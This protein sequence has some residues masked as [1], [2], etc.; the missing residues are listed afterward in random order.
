MKY[1]FVVLGCLVGT[2]VN[3]QFND[4]TN[5]FIKHSS[6]G[7]INK[8]NDQNSYVLNNTLRLNFYRKN[9]SV[10]TTNS[11]IYG[12]QQHQLANND[13]TATVDFDL[14]K[15]DRH[16][17]YWGLLNYEKS[18]SLKI[19]NRFQGGLGLGYYLIDRKAIV[20]QVSNGILYERSDLSSTE[21]ID[22]RDYETYRNSLRFKLRHVFRDVITFEN[23]DLIQHSFSDRKDYI[24]KSNTNLSVKLYKWFS[25]AV[26]VT[27]NKLNVTERENLLVNYGLTFERYF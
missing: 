23:I 4:S 17:Y 13:Y 16:L 10:N 1:L 25:I 9:F 22:H 18:F 27:Y 26:T 2:S 6:T 19:R 3:A 20:I 14:Y 15:T 12:K 21:T 5:Y 24:I 8:T 7:I 11:W